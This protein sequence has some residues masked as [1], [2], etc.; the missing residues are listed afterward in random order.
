MANPIKDGQVVNDKMFLSPA[1]ANT[2]V[3]TG[4][5]T[6]TDDSPQIQ[7]LDANGANRNINLP[8]V[9]NTNHIF[10]IYNS[11]S[12]AFNLVVKSGATTVATIAQ[13]QSGLIFSNGVTWIAFATST[14][15]GMVKIAT[16]TLSVAGTITFSSIPGT[17]LAL[18]I[19]ATV[20]SAGAVV[21][22]NAEMFFNGDTVTTNYA[23]QYLQV[24]N[25]GVT[26]GNLANPLI[27]AL[28]LS[29]DGANIASQIEITI[30][31]YADANWHKLYSARG[32]NTAATRVLYPDGRWANTAAIT[33][34]L[35]QGVGTANF[36]ANSTATLW[37][38]S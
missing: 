10:F 3:L 31:N 21:N 35:L 15:A 30:H 36:A 7:Y 22:D 28:I 17:Y 16:V 25:G 12:P 24:N 27:G 29:T 37:G 20:R 11:A 32:G 18:K 23:G 2:Q 19:I 4:D 38:M 26:A 13:G 33:S 34:I 5:L 8:A 6:L 14:A 1:T 9:A